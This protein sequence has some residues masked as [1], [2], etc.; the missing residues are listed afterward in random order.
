MTKRIEGAKK[1]RPPK[2]NAPTCRVVYRAIIGGQTETAAARLA[3]VS[4]E[5]LSKWK[6]AG[7][8]HD[9]SCELDLHECLLVHSLEAAKRRF[10]L[11]LKRAESILKGEA[12]SNIKRIGK[13][14][15]TANAWLLERRFNDEFGKK[16]E[17]VHSGEINHNNTVR[18]ELHNVDSKQRMAMSEAMRKRAEL[19]QAL[20]LPDNIIDAELITTSEQEQPVLIPS[21]TPD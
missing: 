16:A 20:L 19:Q 2:F 15:W 11:N 14:E 7:M 3:R 5:N 8:K 18:I 4:P 9:R 21:S 10:F 6:I 17:V 12:V 1:G 13:K